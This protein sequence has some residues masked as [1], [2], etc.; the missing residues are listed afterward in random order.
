VREL[1][2]VYIGLTAEYIRLVLWDCHRNML[3]QHNQVR[4]FLRSSFAQFRGDN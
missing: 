2:S 1:K 4:I 3:N